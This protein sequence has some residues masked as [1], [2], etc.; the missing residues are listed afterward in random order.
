[1]KGFTRF[2]FADVSTIFV[3]YSYFDNFSIE[4]AIFSS[5]Y[6]RNENF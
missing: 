2:Q 6:L 5:P 1:L 3:F 4:W